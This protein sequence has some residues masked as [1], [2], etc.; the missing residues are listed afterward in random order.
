MHQEIIIASDLLSPDSIRT[1]DIG[2]S[3]TVD[4]MLLL[5]TDPSEQGDPS[6]RTKVAFSFEALAEALGT[7]SESGSIFDISARARLLMEITLAVDE[8]AKRVYDAQ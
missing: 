5:D 4:Q 8:L 6:A 3:T 1:K 2:L 7:L